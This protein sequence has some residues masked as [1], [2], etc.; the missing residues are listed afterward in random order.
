MDCVSFEALT[1]ANYVC[2]GKLVII[3]TE[4]V[5]G[6]ACSAYDVRAMR[7]IFFLKQRSFFSPLSMHCLD[8][9]QT[10]EEVKWTDEAKLLAH[11]FLPG[12][13]TI[14]LERKKTSK[15]PMFATSFRRDLAIRIPAHPV[16]RKFAAYC[17]V[18]LVATSANIS[19][20]PS[21]ISLKEVRKPPFSRLPFLEGGI[22]QYKKASTIVKCLDKKVI[23]LRK[24]AIPVSE[25]EKVIK[26]PLKIG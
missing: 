9:K 16:F 21:P 20:F 4:T 18:P 26:K 12:P 10:L 7:Q 3:P 13:L 8:I 5:Y 11:H 14:I 25:I 15:I 24:G 6:L 23:L 19:M 22:C 17:K 1:V 2:L